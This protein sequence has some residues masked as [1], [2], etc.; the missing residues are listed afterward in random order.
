MES[1]HKYDAYQ[2]NYNRANLNLPEQIEIIW[3][4]IYIM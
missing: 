2:E 1:S 4:S 3:K